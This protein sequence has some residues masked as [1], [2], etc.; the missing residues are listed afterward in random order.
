MLHVTEKIVKTCELF[1]LMI[2]IVPV[3]L[4]S[5][6]RNI[7]FLYVCMY[8][9]MCICMWLHMYGPLRK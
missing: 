8:V 1:I 5:D 4:Y 9:C 6:T 7:P 2:R 3:V